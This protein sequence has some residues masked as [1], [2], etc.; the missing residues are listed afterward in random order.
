MS[1]S[2]IGTLGAMSSDKNQAKELYD[3]IRSHTHIEVQKT[4][5]K[6]QFYGH[7]LFLAP[8]R[9]MAVLGI[10]SRV[11]LMPLLVHYFMSFH[12]HGEF[13][14]AQL[15]GNV[16]KPRFFNGLNSRRA[17]WKLIFIQE[18]YQAVALV[19]SAISRILIH[20]LN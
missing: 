10:R 2:N 1:P 6:L 11:Y 18:N 9:A 20:H 15:V 7:K 3:F 17:N 8:S 5:L 14:F 12:I 16:P 13:Q 19:H 4:L